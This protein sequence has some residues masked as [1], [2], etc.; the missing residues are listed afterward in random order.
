M[1]HLTEYKL[2]VLKVRTICSTALFFWKN[3]TKIYIQFDSK[4]F[5]IITIWFYISIT[6]VTSLLQNP[7]RCNM[8]TFVTDKNKSFVPLLCRLPWL[9]F[10]R[11]NQR[12][13]MHET[14]LTCQNKISTSHFR[15][16]GY[17]AKDLKLEHESE[18]I[19]Y[20]TYSRY[21][22]PRS[23]HPLQHI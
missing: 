17:A 10:P 14:M 22:P 23:S 8:W 4:T 21:F 3:C 6:N 1:L 18:M 13:N 5:C 20:H 16:P 15:N 12:G 9:N 19:L 2:K 7:Y 11:F